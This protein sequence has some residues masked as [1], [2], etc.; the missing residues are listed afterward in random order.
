MTQPREKPF[1]WVSWLV[2]VA[3]GKILIPRF[4]KYRS[5]TALATTGRKFETRVVLLNVRSI[6]RKF[7]GFIEYSPG[8]IVRARRRTLRSEISQ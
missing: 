5:I 2:D 4:S 6:D 7:V 1:I 8:Q 3:S